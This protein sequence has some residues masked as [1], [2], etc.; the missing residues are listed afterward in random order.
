MGMC[1]TCLET[2]AD[3]DISELEMGINEDTKR[4]FEIMMFCLDIKVTRESK[5]TT[6]L[7]DACYVRIISF[8]KFK[9]LSLK[10]DAYLKSLDPLLSKV[11]KKPSVYVDANGIKHE[12][13]LDNDEYGQCV[14]E[15]VPQIKI[16]IEVKK[17]NTFGDVQRDVKDEDTTE[18]A[19]SDKE[20][21]SVVQKV[22]HENIK[23]GTKENPPARK[24]RGRPKKSE[25]AEHLKQGY[26]VCEECGKSV[27]NLKQH[28]ARHVPT[29]ER[30]TVQCDTCPK[31]FCTKGALREH[32]KFTHLGMK[33]KCDVCNKE[34]T[35][36]TTHKLL[37]HDRDALPFAC[38][39]CGR[40]FV[41]QSALA[42][43]MIT[44]TKGSD[45]L[46][47]E[48]DICHIKFNRKGV[49]S[50]HMRRVHEKE[51]KYQCEFCSKG[52][53]TKYS[54]ELHIRSHK[55]E[56]PYK[57][58]EC[59]KTFSHSTSHKNHQLIHT[60]VKNYHC[61]VC[62]MAFMRVEY[63]RKHM[64]SHTK[65]KNHPCR[66]CGKRFGRTDHRRKHE[67]TAHQKH[68]SAD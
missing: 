11:D 46:V 1:R 68:L 64:I 59:G 4:S 13:F 8:Y 14:V 29:G 25:S 10:N 43:H 17:E 52:F 27:R 19:E 20:P 5:I 31:V 21:L 63:L 51:R 57:C 61:E 32:Y 62:N 6:N 67:I 33:F 48:C 53:F 44:H 55:K 35:N 39:S 18:D 60:G 26:Q 37:A 56:R 38:V 16:E 66:Y 34:V 22:K 47:H 24:K 58:E 49:L 9:N 3:K 36:L 15:D 12:N 7:C 50:R 65:E 40:R 41:T 54:L 45:T 23:K 42:T 2:P 28:T 30:K